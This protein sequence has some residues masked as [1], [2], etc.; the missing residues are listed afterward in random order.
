MKTLKIALLVLAMTASAFSFAA[1]K[2]KA[3][4]MDCELASSSFI[5]MLKGLEESQKERREAQAAAQAAKDANE[6]LKLGWTLLER[7]PEPALKAARDV[8]KANDA[9]AGG[10]AEYSA[11]RFSYRGFPEILKKSMILKDKTPFRPVGAPRWYRDRDGYSGTSWNYSIEPFETEDTKDLIGKLAVGFVG[12]RAFAGV[13]VGEEQTALQLVGLDGQLFEVRKG[14]WFGHYVGM[15]HLHVWD[16]TQTWEQFRDASDKI[17]EAGMLRELGYVWDQQYMG[18][19]TQMYKPEPYLQGQDAKTVAKDLG[20]IIKARGTP[21]RMKFVVKTR[22][23]RS[24]SSSGTGFRGTTN[25]YLK[26]FETL[27]VISVGR[28]KD[29]EPLRIVVAKENG[30]TETREYNILRKDQN[31]TGLSDILYLN[32]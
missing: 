21:V 9:A 6:V 20:A 1:G 26:S 18:N 2:K 8:L 15:T 29:G 23:Y 17:L 31:G 14:V 12:Y 3:G 19:W 25:E 10:D 24:L 28:V 30:S 11:A 13:V 16:P 22:E 5:S 27:N 7:F 4:T 32:E